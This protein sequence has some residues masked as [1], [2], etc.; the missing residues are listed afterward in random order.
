[1]Q[2]SLP[3]T[4]I[5][6]KGMLMVCLLGI[7]STAVFAGDTPLH[8]IHISVCE[9]R[10]NAQAAS[11]QVS[12]KIFI[13]DFERA[14]SKEGAPALHIGGTAEIMDADSYI[15]SYLNKHFSISL[16]GSALASSFAGKELSDDYLAVWCYFEFPA[17]L[18]GVKQCSMSND[19]LFALYEDQRNIMDIRMNSSHKDYTIFQSGR[20]TW[21]YSF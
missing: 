20:S 21:S 5:G 11:F 8:D 17:K 15:V 19:V 18:S 10:Y 9:V 12:L 7:F 3:R 16:D 4:S 6:L 1:M 13:D 2:R 14:M